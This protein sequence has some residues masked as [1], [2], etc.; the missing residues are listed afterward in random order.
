MTKLKNSPESFNKRL[1]K[2]EKK[3]ISKLKDRL[4]EIVQSKKQKEK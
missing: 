1:D 2:T 4:F 3:I